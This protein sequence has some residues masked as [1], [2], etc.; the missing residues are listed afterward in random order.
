MRKLFENIGLLTNVV[1]KSSSDAHHFKTYE[2][3]KRWLKATTHHDINDVDVD[4]VNAAMHMV[5]TFHDD[6]SVTP[7]VND[8]SIITCKE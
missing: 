7:D 4:F 3:F 1:I 8:N 2:I 6:G 5:A